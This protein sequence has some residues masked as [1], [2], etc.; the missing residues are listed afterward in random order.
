MILT[1]QWYIIPD[2]RYTPVQANDVHSIAT[3]LFYVPVWNAFRQ[4]VVVRQGGGGGGGLLLYYTLLVAFFR[5]V[6]DAVVR[7]D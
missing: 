3:R 1:Y 4:A 6:G 5:L 7:F 2:T